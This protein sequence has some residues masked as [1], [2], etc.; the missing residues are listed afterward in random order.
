MACH[1]V[2][3]VEI[4]TGFVPVPVSGT[5]AGI[6]IIAISIIRIPSVTALGTGG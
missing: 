1:S 6:G 5:T 2:A 3:D 4:G